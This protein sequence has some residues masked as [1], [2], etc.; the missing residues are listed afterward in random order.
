MSLEELS[1]R[2]L[3]E[4]YA[5]QLR[6]VFGGRKASGVFTKHERRYLK[7]H[8]VLRRFFNGYKKGG[9]VTSLTAKTLRVLEALDV[10]KP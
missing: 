4:F 2:N 9:S 6:Q 5:G 3:V 1:F 10:A 7:K 8:G